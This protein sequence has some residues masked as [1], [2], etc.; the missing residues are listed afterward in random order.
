[1]ISNQF[2]PLLYLIGY[3]TL[4]GKG[5]HCPLWAGSQSTHEQ[6]AIIG[7]LN[8]LNYCVIFTVHAKFL[9]VAM[10]RIIQAG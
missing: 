3:R 4:Y 2:K 10:S 7:V 5:P 1:M 8:S 9:S 6:I